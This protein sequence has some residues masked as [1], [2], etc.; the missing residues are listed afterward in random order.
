MAGTSFNPAFDPSAAFNPAF[1]S[2][3]FNPKFVYSSGL[4]LPA[5][6]SPS[7]SSTPVAS[8]YSYPSEPV[9]GTDPATDQVIKQA[10]ALYPFYKQQLIDQTNLQF[11]ANQANLQAT[12]PY[13]SQAAAEA[14][15]RNLAA[16]K[17]FY[18]TK[19]QSPA[20]VQDIMASKQGQIASAADAEYR[21]AMGTAAQQD[22]ATNFARRYAGQTFSTA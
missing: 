9:P 4:N 15:A 3:N 5:T 8:S 22:A 16:S 18:K 12:Y 2:K 11:A 10:Q 1:T 14:T 7:T 17:D 6:Y 21:R 13:L 20:T 19:Q